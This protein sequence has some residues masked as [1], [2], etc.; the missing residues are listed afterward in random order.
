[1]TVTESLTNDFVARKSYGVIRTPP[2]G[3]TTEVP[4]R[5]L[6]GVFPVWISFV[7]PLGTEKGSSQTTEVIF[8]GE[9]KEFVP[10]TTLGRKL[11]SLRRRAIASGM[12]LL[13]E[14][15]V[16]E[17]VRRRRGELEYDEADLY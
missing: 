10:R 17:E 12:R 13:S 6:P 8:P 15:E 9:R 2:I 7:L 11:T 1:M 3:F 16:L 5:G 14:D 4:G